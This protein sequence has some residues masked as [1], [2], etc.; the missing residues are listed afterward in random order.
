MALVIMTRT[1][2]PMV[3]DVHEAKTNMLKLM[4]LLETGQEREIIVCNRGVPV[5]RWVPFSSDANQPRPFGIAK[6]KYPS[7]NEYDFFA[8][9]KEIAQEFDC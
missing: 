6:D 2:V 4:R 9:D 7:A 8:L 3:V 5:L 1:E